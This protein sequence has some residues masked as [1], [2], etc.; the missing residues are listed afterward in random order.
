LEQRTGFLD[1][2]G[3][4]LGGNRDFLAK[5]R[6]HN[7]ILLKLPHAIAQRCTL[8]VGIVVWRI[9]SKAT[10]EIPNAISRESYVRQFKPQLGGSPA[11]L[12]AVRAAMP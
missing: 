2:F 12:S 11:K 1:Q 5:A 9:A 6:S 7:H 10:R 4:A 8:H 3:R